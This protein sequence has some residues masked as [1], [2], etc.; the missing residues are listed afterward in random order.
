M[1]SL[2]LVDAVDLDYEEYANLQKRAFAAL[3]A[4]SQVSDAFMSADYY[5]WKYNPPFGKG[6]IATIRERGALVAANGMLPLEICRDRIRIKGWQ[7]CDTATLPSARGKGYFPKCVRGLESVLDP[8]DIFFGFPNKNSV[9]GFLK[10]GWKER[11]IVRTWLNYRGFILKRSNYSFSQIQRFGPEQDW[12]TE[13]LSG[14]G[15]SMLTKGADYMNWRY[16]DH[17]I[18]GYS[19]TLCRDG[20]RQVGYVVARRVDML[21]MRIMVIMDI[22]AL[23][24]SIEGALLR[25]IAW[26]GYKEGVKWVALLDSGL[27]LLNGLRACFLP[28]WWRVLPK[29]QVLMGTVKS[30]T[31]GEKIFQGPWRVQT[32]DWDG[33]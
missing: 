30:G 5:R 7:S 13:Q 32:G 10:V 26:L 21:G 4:K 31:Q 6:I 8:S 1:V 12:I 16:M 25:H 33:F 22:G 3:L 18:H 19:A 23:G 14:C 11:Q 17:P 15:R 2:D 9:S 28:I 20:G 24:S 27:P 29:R